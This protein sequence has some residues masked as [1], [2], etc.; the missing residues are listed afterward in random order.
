MSN[1]EYEIRDQSV[2]STFVEGFAS[3]VST[4]VAA[5]LLFNFYKTRQEIKQS[6]ERRMFLR[7]VSLAMLAMLTS[8]IF[9]LTRSIIHI[10]MIA[11]DANIFEYFFG[12]GSSDCSA[13]FV[14]EQISRLSASLSISIHFLVF[15]QIIMDNFNPKTHSVTHVPTPFKILQS[16][17]IVRSI[18]T[19]VSVMIL[20]QSKLFQISSSSFHVCF[21]VNNSRL[22]VVYSISGGMAS[23]ICIVLLFTFLCKSWTVKFFSTSCL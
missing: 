13:C 18:C 16:I 22:N 5:Y 2:P 19:D 9:S 11:I 1:E 12:C 7:S 20:L 21:M 10:E 14:L 15:V 6:T 8:V 3:I 23:I 17:I 4:F